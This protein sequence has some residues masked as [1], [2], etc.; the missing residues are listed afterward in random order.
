MAFEFKKQGAD[1]AS[2]P[3]RM[4]DSPDPNEARVNDF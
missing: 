3:N 1:K 2:P 4:C